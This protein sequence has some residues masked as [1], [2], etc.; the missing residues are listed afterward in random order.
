MMSRRCVQR[1]VLKPV[2]T[3]VG[4]RKAPST[5][6]NVPGSARRVI[7]VNAFGHVTERAA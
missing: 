4:H 5:T 3:A 1:R 7:A 6:N 2:P